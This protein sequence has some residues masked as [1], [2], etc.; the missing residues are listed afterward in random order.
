M[1]LERGSLLFLFGLL[2]HWTRGRERCGKAYDVMTS[3]SWASKE[4]SFCA[5]ADTQ[6]LCSY[7]HLILLPLPLRYERVNTRQKG[8][9]RSWR[10][11]PLAYQ[12]LLF[13]ITF[14]F[15]LIKEVVTSFCPSSIVFGESCIFLGSSRC[16]K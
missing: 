15:F 11:T 7:W 9:L 3:C 2:G 6:L 12:L 8:V 5:P 10:Y 16:I 13:A 4:I 14:F 1:N